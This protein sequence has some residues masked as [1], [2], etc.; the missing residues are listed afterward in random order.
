MKTEQIL[1]LGRSCVGISGL[2]E[3][4]YGRRRSKA[5]VEKRRKRLHI[6]I[7]RNGRKNKDRSGDCKNRR[8]CGSL[9]RRQNSESSACRNFSM[10]RRKKEELLSCR[11][12]TK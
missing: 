8:K 10:R 9:I 4:E 2:D 6:S 12:E 3:F 1:Q 5:E 7:G 11:Q